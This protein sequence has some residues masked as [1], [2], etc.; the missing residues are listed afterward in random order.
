MKNLGVH[1]KNKLRFK[2]GKFKFKNG[3]VSIVAYHYIR[4]PSFSNYKNFNY[5]KFSNFKKQIVLK[6]IFK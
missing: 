5:L 3:T 4:E 6:K 1:N 2:F